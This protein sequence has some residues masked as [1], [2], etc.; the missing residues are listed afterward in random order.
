MH[1]VSSAR[2][3][4]KAKPTPQTPNTR[5]TRSL[6]LLLEALGQIADRERVAVLDPAVLRVEEFEEDVGD[7]ERFEL[8]PERVCT[9]VEVVLVALAG[10]DVDRAEAAQRVCVATRHP[11]RI[12]GEPALPDVV[13]EHPG[14][15]VER[16]V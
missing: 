7:P 6:P 16:Q 4:G 9:E 1:P 8:A 5:L 3:E 10:V 12:P 13:P 15:R 11:H 2:P 14:G